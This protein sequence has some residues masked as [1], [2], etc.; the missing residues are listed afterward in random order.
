M[1]AWVVAASTMAGDCLQEHLLPVTDLR[2]HFGSATVLTIVFQVE[3]G[4][5]NANKLSALVGPAT[6]LD[7]AGH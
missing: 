4:G 5:V 6:A 3:T 7:A 1:N 2:W